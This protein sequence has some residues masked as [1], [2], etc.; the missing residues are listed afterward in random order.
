MYKILS[1]DNVSFTKSGIYSKI[2]SH[3]KKWKN[4]IPKEKK[5]SLRPTPR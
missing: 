4:V 5:H 2:V 1:V 3:I